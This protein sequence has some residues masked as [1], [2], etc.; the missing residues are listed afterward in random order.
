M[1]TKIWFSFGK[2]KC[3][4][5]TKIPESLS[6]CV[7]ECSDLNTNEYSAELGSSTLHNSCY[8]TVLWRQIVSRYRKLSHYQYLG[9]NQPPAHRVFL[10]KQIHAISQATQASM[11]QNTV[12]MWRSIYVPITVCHSPNT[13]PGKGVSPTMLF[14]TICWPQV[15]ILN[16]LLCLFCDK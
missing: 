11:P 13:S 9:V 16:V 4:S 6:M 8:K 14:V 1:S 12:N 7:L 5:A 3:F 15:T 10:S 2:W